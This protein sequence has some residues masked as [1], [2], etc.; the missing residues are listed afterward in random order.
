MSIPAADVRFLQ[1]VV[2][3]MRKD[4]LRNYIY[5]P[6]RAA[7][8]MV[9][10]FPGNDGIKVA[11]CFS[12][13]DRGISVDDA[14]K[15][16][17]DHM[18]LDAPSSLS[19]FFLLRGDVDRWRWSGQVAF[20][21]GKRD[22]DDRN[23]L[24]CAKRETYEEVGFPLDSPEFLYLGR[25]PDTKIRSRE[26]NTEGLVMSRFVF[27]HIGEMTPT[28]HYSAHEVE[29]IQWVPIKELTRGN[30][31]WNT[32]E[33]PVMTFVHWSYWEMKQFVKESFPS[34][35]VRFPSL[36][37]PQGWHL[38][39]QALTG[40]SQLLSYDGRP[41]L[42]FPYFRVNVLW[43]QWLLVHP[44][45]G[46]LNICGE[47]PIYA[48]HIIGLM[49]VF[50]I[51]YTVVDTMKYFVF[52]LWH[53]WC[54]ALEYSREMKFGTVEQIMTGGARSARY[55]NPFQ[56]P[57][58]DEDEITLNKKI[59][60]FA[61]KP[62]K[63][64]PKSQPDDH[65]KGFDRADLEARNQSRSMWSTKDPLQSAEVSEAD[66]EEYARLMGLPK[67]ASKEFKADGVVEDGAAVV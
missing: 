58:A 54:L 18:D 26:I 13:L 36:P 56:Q 5:G 50:S 66:A 4:A 3:G 2:N 32:V 33:H 34:V 21:G 39:G 59:I 24:D 20:P 17:Q 64:G 14:L 65:I 15:R 52:G 35:L 63:Q 25:L 40:T 6:N 45:H 42:D 46:W 31:S 61:G 16:L 12:H 53:I 28:L 29:A 9:M 37:M 7:Q 60:L 11:R 55:L 41:R 62:K 23:D 10:R 47:R 51:F 57:T 44:Y 19:L 48:D 27:L 49:L 22:N 1:V 30:L 67:P 38:W 8:A 43:V